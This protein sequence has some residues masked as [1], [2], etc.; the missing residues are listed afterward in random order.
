M[1]GSYHGN[2]DRGLLQ[3]GLALGRGDDDLLQPAAG[4][5]LSASAAAAAG[6]ASSAACA[7]AGANASGSASGRAASDV[8]NFISEFLPG[9][10]DGLRRSLAPKSSTPR[11]LTLV[12]CIHV[13]ET[14]WKINFR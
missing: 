1:T 12:I 11:E 10:M 3:I 9:V 7:M 2:G 13:T 6:V 5:G 4:V 14:V 8:W